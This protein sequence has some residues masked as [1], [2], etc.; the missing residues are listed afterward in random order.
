MAV[1]MQDQRDS[2][3][4]I[5]SD[6]REFFVTLDARIAQGAER[7]QVQLAEALEVSQQ[8]IQ[9]YEVGQRRIPLG[10]ARCGQDAAA[11]CAQMLDTVLTQAANR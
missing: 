3:M 1:F 4:T 5:S 10:S 11:I 9:A 7:A 6:E 2:A 8:T